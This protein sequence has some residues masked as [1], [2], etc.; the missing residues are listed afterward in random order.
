M[1]YFSKALQIRKLF[2]DD[3]HPDVAVSYNNIG[4][5]YK[6]QGDYVKALECYHKTLSSWEK[7]LDPEHPYMVMIR[8]KIADVEAKM[9][10]K[11]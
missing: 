3:E 1:E 11:E 5:I 8:E 2:F 7:L 10:E 6:E 9:K 4:N